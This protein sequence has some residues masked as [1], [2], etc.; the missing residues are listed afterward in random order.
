[1]IVVVADE[2]ELEG[3]EQIV[4]AAIRDW[5]SEAGGVAVFRC[6]VPESRGGSVEVDALVCTPQGATV[7]EVKGF[8]ARQDGVLATPPNGPWTVDGAEAALYHAV[9]VPNPFVQVRRQ[10]FAAKNLLQQSG[11]FG[12][13][14]AVVVLVPQ[15]GSQITL[16]E[17]RIADG[18][19]AV[20]VD[21]DDATALRD[22]FHAETGR[23][24]RL[25][26]ND[27]RRVFAALN[28]THL[29]PS[30][31]DLADQG[32]PARLDP[33]TGGKTTTP[34]TADAEAAPSRA[35]G[36]T[37]TGTRV[38]QT[39]TPG[40]LAAIDRLAHRQ[41]A[42]APES[43]GT[44]EAADTTGS[45]PEGESS[46][47]SA[48]SAGSPLMPGREPAQ[49]STEP[50]AESNSDT[51]VEAE[52]DT[53]PTQEPTREPGADSLTA[54][55]SASISPDAAQD[56]TD[57]A[58]SPT[59]TPAGTGAAA[60]TLGNSATFASAPPVSDS[61][62]TTPLSS[63][64]AAVP[65][66]AR[67]A[68]GNDTAGSTVGASEGTRANPVGPD[69]RG[70]APVDSDGRGH[71]PDAIDTVVP[72]S[73]S[74]ESSRP[75]P[76]DSRGNNVE[77]GDIVAAD[78]TSPRPA[79]SPAL[80]P[81]T[82]S[83]QTDSAATD[84]ARA[85]NAQTP[86][87]SGSVGDGG[88]VTQG[89]ADLP[90]SAY[91]GARGGDRDLV[92]DESPPIPQTGG[93]EAGVVSLTKSPSVG[94]PEPSANSSAASTSS[95]GT[96]ASGAAVAASGA[97]V[98]ASG[99]TGDA[100]GAT[101]DASGPAGDASG[102]AG[103]TS[104]P[105]GDAS[106]PTGGT[107]SDTGD[108]S[109][110]TGDSASAA[111]DASGAPIGASP[112]TTYE[113]SDYDDDS[114]DDWDDDD[115]ADYHPSDAAYAAGA[116][117]GAAGIAG[118]AAW[119]SRQPAG[120][121][122]HHDDAEQF[123]SAEHWSEWVDRDTTPV[124]APSANREQRGSRSPSSLLERWRNTP[125]RERP[126]RKRRL[127][128]IGPGIGLLLFIALFGA[129]FF[130][131]TAVQASRFEMADYDRMCTDRKPF[132]NAAEFQR[133]GARPTY[134]SGDLAQMVA[135]SG[136]P[137]WRPS[138]TSTV[139]LIACLRQES[140]G[141]LVQTCQYPAAPGSP[142]GR[143]VNLFRATYEI[144]VYELRTGREAG[145][146]IMIGERYS[147]DPANTDPDRCRAAADAPDVLGRRLGQP[148]TAQV[149]GFLA[150]LVHADR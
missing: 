31:V 118:A 125:V 50:P 60:T 138:D 149:T 38:A 84:L 111:G 78:P 133:D 59:G 73:D 137:A 25:S 5:A 1:M 66:N 113:S 104:G 135:T 26:V 106:G 140:L 77:P 52:M 7:L 88:S 130:A 43:T 33:P 12:W 74:N 8:T 139:Q 6:H 116:T 15:P 22:Y 121:A 109:G 45:L 67:D 81:T 32:F 122:P 95:P 97:A 34:A 49:D 144:T 37:R 87:E 126:E 96:A 17:S 129:G 127:P 56:N 120:P 9:R 61:A 112:P 86:S 20:L 28:L 44:R 14:N 63:D 70:A 27:V 16:E 123:D 143:T 35:R 71:A 30:R 64:V 4:A 107:S 41:H 10:V 13:V 51:H 119:S 47:A 142:I 136:S 85:E 42:V 2:T 69:T 24:V 108:A 134:L 82:V 148:S 90:A 103:D 36:A 114:D 145:R 89:S 98:A 23:T 110:P 65:G 93:A 115:Y 3:A 39:S 128:R 75:T 46:G 94:S 132:P 102:P 76:D 124:R 83:G 91:G 53:A 101:G 80:G 58:T 99:A 19:R 11:I 141:E 150:P 54:A 131:I 68:A 117:T 79:S 92:G 105:A 146:A 48:L 29:L 57:T 62:D 147:A 100:V 18:Y 40:F 21:R 72:G 55:D